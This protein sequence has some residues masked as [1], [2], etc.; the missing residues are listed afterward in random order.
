MDGCTGYGAAQLGEVLSIA[1]TLGPP[2]T[3]TALARIEYAREWAESHYITPAEFEATLNAVQQGF[4]TGTEKRE[5]N[6]LNKLTVCAADVPYEPPRWLIAPYFQRGKGTM[7]QA[8]PGTGKTAFMCAIAAHV[9]TGTPLLGI[10]IE[11]PGNVLICSVEDDLPVLRGRL[12]A[13]GADIRKCFLLTSG[14]GITFN[15]PKIEGLIKLHKIEL[16]VFDPFQAFVGAKVD[17]NRSNETRPVLDSLFEMCQR[18]DCACAIVAHTGKA[19][20]DKSSVYR[21]LGSV[22]IPGA[23]RSIL[24]I[25][26]NPENERELVAVHVKCS[27]APKGKGIGYQIGDRGGVQWTGFRDLTAA[28]VE[29]VKKRK[30]AGVPYENEPLVQVLNQLIAD[31]PGGGFWSYGEVM[32]IGQRLL[33]FPPCENSKELPQKLSGSLLR[34]LQQRDGLIVTTGRKSKGIRGIRIERYQ[35]PDGFQSHMEE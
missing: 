30:E 25:I 20:G 32:E 15:S 23:M 16:V 18:N 4:A 13:S 9:S 34:E 31:R 3:P 7:I 24:H 2:D 11:R 35:V 29:I 12:E 8:E 10:P 14:N 22:D 5:E 17:M 6:E 33:G 26:K 19:S 28:D 27:N 1:M 21:A